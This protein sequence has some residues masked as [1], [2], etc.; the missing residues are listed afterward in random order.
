MAAASRPPGLATE[1]LGPRRGAAAGRPV[2]FIQKRKPVY[3]L[4][5]AH[6][7]AGIMAR[8]SRV[9]LSTAWLLRA[10]PSRRQSKP[11]ARKQAACCFP[12]ACLPRQW[13]GRPRCGVRRAHHERRLLLRCAARPLF[14]G[15]PLQGGLRVS[16]SLSLHITSPP[17]GRGAEAPRIKRR[18]GPG[19]VLLRTGGARSE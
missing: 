16:L 10:L 2:H 7:P 18:A 5:L 15:F 14:Q 6:G 9:G 4:P 11:P 13:D 1:T 8:F 17:A 19:L 3:F 12:R